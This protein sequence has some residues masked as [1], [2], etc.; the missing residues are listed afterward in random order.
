MTSTLLGLF[1]IAL[2]MFEGMASSVFVDMYRAFGIDNYWPQRVHK[3]THWQWTLP[4]GVVL[5]VVLVWKANIVSV[6]R[7]RAID[8]I[9]CLVLF[10]TLAAWL[11]SAFFYRAR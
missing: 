4:C 3:F 5:A 2:L 1:G 8:L 6:R 11:W 7:N 10:G 9:V